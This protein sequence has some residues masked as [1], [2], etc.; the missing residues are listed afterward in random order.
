MAGGDV[1]VL[2]GAAKN[3]ADRFRAVT[4]A[5]SAGSDD[6]RG[7]LTQLAKRAISRI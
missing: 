6:A 2:L 4:L 5:L 1:A 7:P 3:S